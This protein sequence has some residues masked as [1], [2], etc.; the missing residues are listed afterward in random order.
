M[1]GPKIVNNLLFL[2]LII[3][4]NH[5]HCR[6]HV[7]SSKNCAYTYTKNKHSKTIF[8]IKQIV[9][10]SGCEL[11]CT[12]NAMSCN[13]YLKKIQSNCNICTSLIL[14]WHFHFCFCSLN[15]PDFFSPP[16]PIY[17]YNRSNLRIVLLQRKPKI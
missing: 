13:I 3:Q 14:P 4:G 12:V 6:L 15:C 8:N 16:A 9:F 1:D 7:S 11:T 17:I 2:T 10:N 5:N